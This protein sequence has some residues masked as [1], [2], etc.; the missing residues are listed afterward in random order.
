ML[1]MLSMQGLGTNALSAI[2]FGVIGILLMLFGFKLFDWITPK[3]DI[4]K[5]LAENH[6]IAVAIV[7]AATILGISIIVAR[8]IGE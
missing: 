2:V 5:E 8:I 3:M 1:A 4:E 6:N 7:I